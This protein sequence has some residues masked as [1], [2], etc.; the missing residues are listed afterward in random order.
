MVRL[1]FSHNVFVFSKWTQ[2]IRFLV[3]LIALPWTTVLVRLQLRSSSTSKRVLWMHIYMLKVCKNSSHPSPTL[4]CLL[5]LLNINL[6]GFWNKILFCSFLAMTMH[7]TSNLFGRKKKKND[8]TIKRGKIWIPFI[9]W[10]LGLPPL[11]VP[12]RTN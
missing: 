2:H 10:G 8:P 12:E 4:H 1:W 6:K 3:S 7:C 5:Y 9:Q 11:Q